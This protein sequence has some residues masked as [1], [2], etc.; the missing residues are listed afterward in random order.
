M[1][2][3]AAIATEDVLSN[4]YYTRREMMTPAGV[5]CGGR[6]A[7]DRDHPGNEDSGDRRSGKEDA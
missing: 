1:K 5:F 7:V 2:T 6:K 4:L 3:V